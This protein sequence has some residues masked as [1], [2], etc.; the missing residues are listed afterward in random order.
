MVSVPAGPG[1]SA[2][3]PLAA[4]AGDTLL[5]VDGHALVF[6]AFYGMPVMTTS[7]GE[8]TQVAFGFT[9]M[10]LKALADVRPSH[11]VAAFDP[12]GPTFRHAE[13]EGYKAQRPPA[14]EE[15]RTQLPLC[16]EIVGA[17]GIPIVELPGFEADDVIGTL[18]RRAEDQALDVIILTG[19]LDALQ[20]V[21]ERTRVLASR[22]G[23]TD[24][25]VYDL[26]AVRER[27]GFEPP[28]VIDYKAL[29]GD[30]SDNIPGV[31]GIGEKT[32]K[33]LIQEHGP[34]EDI[35]AA[36]PA[37]KE[38]RVRRSLTE[39][40]DQARLSK[41]MA[42]IV[43]DLDI[44]FDIAGARR[45]GYE[46]GPIRELFDRWEFRSLVARLPPGGTDADLPP[47]GSGP[48]LVGAG[49]PLTPAEQATLPLV[50]AP[51]GTDTMV[52][53][54][55][56]TAVDAAARLR[57]A[58]RVAVR[59]LVS[60]PARSGRAVGIAFAPIDD[61]EHAWYVPLEHD[62][63]GGRADAAAA[64]PLLAL[65][66][67]P[68]VSKVA[69]DV[70]RELLVWWARGVEPHGF[71]RDLL[72]MSYLATTRERVP[73]LAVLLDDSCAVSV[74][75]EEALCGSGRSRRTAAQLGVDETAPCSGRIAALYGPLLTV[76]EGALATTPML[77]LHDEMEL[78][79]ASILAR[80]EVTGIGLD[81]E[82]LHG[83]GA[84]LRSRIA[85]VEEGAHGIAGHGFN[86]GSVPQLRTVLYD[87][88]GLTAGR[89]TKTGQ[90]TEADALEALRDESPIAD[91]VLEWRQLR[92]VQDWVGKLPDLAA[93]DGRV[94]TSY[95]QAVASTGRLSSADPN[96]QNIP[97]RTEVG[98]RVRRAFVPERQGW[99]LV[100]ADYS[101][102]ELR[103]LA[104]V[105]N[106][107]VLVEAFRNREDI[108]A[109]TAARVYGV[110]LETVTHE[111]RRLAKVV[112]FGILY[113]LSEYGL[114]RDTGMSREDA[115]AYIDQYF[116]T[117][118]TIAAYQE[119]I[120]LFAR[121]AGYVETLYGRRRHLPNL[122]A[123]QRNIRQGAERQAINM[124]IQGT[125]ADIMKYAMIR[126]DAALRDGGMASRILLQVHD[127][128][129][130]EAPREE[131]V[132]LGDLLRDAMGG[133]ARLVVPLDVEVKVGPSW[134]QLEPVPDAVSA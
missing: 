17:L 21:T 95:N 112:N 43:R 54:D 8:S 121:S 26:A 73:G 79:L 90:T 62:E 1:R 133:A 28:L 50:S 126:A 2:R 13:M 128:L 57:A 101:Q 68:A 24:L 117:F 132:A 116:R 59:T 113:G 15:V 69:Y 18:S 4:V 55:A 42:T 64:A 29:Q 27:Y 97:L 86:L 78:P 31:P 40:V 38:G 98:Q 130:L 76:L 123:A 52:V 115:R 22:R 33:A 9:S 77:A 5:L 32:A 102:I 71:D 7:R 70:K 10:L 19:D 48:G 120:L 111:M 96:L 105:T 51:S 3:V 60:D 61:A 125:A 91:L 16:R 66:A 72:L 85:A 103:V 122:L 11:A 129:V 110:E 36:L 46:A 56:A 83:L 108:H 35:L 65:L 75:T 14:P 106:D 81:P 23:I 80:M 67:D 93:G 41:R 49:A 12:P 25:T 39:H 104:H 47:A 88:L 131:V 6:R 74:E 107:A 45:G 20:L 84:E 82:A 30:A 134:A 92:I 63:L 58:P 99:Q 114:A 127:E 124:P 94:H 109:S 53:R 118:S 89:R 34:L 44:P 37:M 119:S 100:S 87:E